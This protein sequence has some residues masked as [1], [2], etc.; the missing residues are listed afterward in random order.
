MYLLY[1]TIRKSNKT[2]F[3]RRREVVLLDFIL[4]YYKNK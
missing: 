1:K 4:I 3:L 2:I